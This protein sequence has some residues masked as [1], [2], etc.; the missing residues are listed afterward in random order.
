[1]LFSG[2]KLELGETSVRCARLASC[3]QGAV[4]VHL[5]IDEIVVGEWWGTIRRHDLFDKLKILGMVPI[6]EQYWAEVIIV[7]DLGRTMNNHRSNETSR[8][9]STVVRVIPRRSIDISEK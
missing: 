9:L 7:C 1:M 5:A 4:V 2:V 3:N 8:I 6:A